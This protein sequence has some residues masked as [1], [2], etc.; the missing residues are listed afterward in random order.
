MFIENC[1]TVFPKLPISCISVAPTPNLDTW[2]SL[3]WDKM[4][5]QDRM[6][7]WELGQCEGSARGLRALS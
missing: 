2:P 1:G 7:G 3:E 5:R 6:S 4:R